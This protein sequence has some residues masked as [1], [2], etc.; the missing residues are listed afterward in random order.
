MPRRSLVKLPHPSPPEPL[1]NQNN[2]YSRDVEKLGIRNR[3]LEALAETLRV[4]CK[5]SGSGCKWSS[6]AD[7]ASGAE[8][9]AAHETEC[10]FRDR[11]CGIDGCKHMASPDG[12][13]KVCGRG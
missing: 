7:K 12:H 2:L 8:A 11:E 5:W 1:C 4:R 13:T 6:F 3:A 10:S 9:K